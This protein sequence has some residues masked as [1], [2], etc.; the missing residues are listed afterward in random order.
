MTL[1]NFP[2]V[3]RILCVFDF[4]T[5]I[6][7]YNFFL[8]R[9]S[10]VLSCRQTVMMP[11]YYVVTGRDFYGDSIFIL[12]LQCTFYGI[13][14]YNILDTFYC[15]I[16]SVFS[17]YITAYV[18]STWICSPSSLYRCAGYRFVAWVLLALRLVRGARC[19][20]ALGYFHMLSLLLRVFGLVTGLYIYN[21]Q[22]GIFPGQMLLR[23]E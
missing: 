2:I 20:V 13:P 16:R 1:G 21:F 3:S 4:V 14:D 11:V 7:I 22:A 18:F 9:R 6:C 15:L 23:G 17:T 12:F 8:F 10:R 19:S 5:G